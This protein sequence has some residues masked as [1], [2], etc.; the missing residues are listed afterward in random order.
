VIEYV[1]FIILNRSFSPRILST[2]SNALA[3]FVWAA[4]RCLSGGG[5]G[6]FM[7]GGGGGF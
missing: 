6:G 3:I 1:G 5:G 7:Y 2:S 4:V